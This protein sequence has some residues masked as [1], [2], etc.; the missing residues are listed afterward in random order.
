[1]GDGAMKIYTK[2]GDKGKTSLIGG[3]RVSK[4]HARL[5][6]YGTVDELNSTIGLLAREISDDLAKAGRQKD[7]SELVKELTY[8]Q[9]DLF[10]LGSHLACEDADMRRQLP[11]L[12]PSRVSSLEK[13]MDTFSTELKPLKH[14]VLPGG[15]RSACIA[16]MARTI[17]RRAERLIVHLEEIEPN[18]IENINVQYLN[19]LSDYFFVLARHLNRLM[20]VEEPIWA[21]KDRS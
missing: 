18:S 9:S 21:G 11:T 4:A 12:D 8:I 6:A 14:F 2:G 10:D 7:S 20:S 19:R 17:C 16:H 1:M 5:D 13:A 3:K 15:A